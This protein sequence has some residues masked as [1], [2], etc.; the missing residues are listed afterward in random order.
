MRLLPTL[1]S[2]ISFIIIL[3]LLS[4]NDNQNI[5]PINCSITDLVAEP[6]DCNCA[7]NYGLLIDF[8]VTDATGEFF[9]VFVRNDISLGFYKLSDLPITIPKFEQSGLAEDY[10]KVCINNLPNCC[11]EYEWTPPD[12]SEECGIS[13]FTVD[14]GDCTSEETYS[15]TVNFV[16]Q[17]PGHDNFE[18]FDRNG[19]IGNYPL[20][21]LSLTIADFAPSEKEYDFLKV[22]ISDNPDCCQEIEFMAPD[23]LEVPCE[24]FDLVVE[25][26]ECTSEETY[27]LYVNFEYQNAGNDFFDL[28]VRNDV[29]IDFYRL[30]Q[31]PLTIEDFP[32][33]GNDDAYIKVCINDEPDCC[34]ILEFMP[35]EC[36]EDCEIFDVVIETGDCTSDTTYVL[37]LNFEVNNPGNDFFEVFVRNGE[38]ID[39]Y[40]LSNDRP[41]RIEDFPISGNDYDY[42]KI[43]INDEPDC[44]YEWEY[45]PPEC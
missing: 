35:P 1:A 32:F 40:E 12:C 19:R 21:S 26:G 45:M 8:K 36:E 37:E 20:S 14:V 2:L 41:L 9:E 16:T 23:C 11:A 10:I 7:D 38:L 43:C 28:Y 30:D 31:L 5:A 44:C 42:I 27:N 17:N 39:Y 33:S 18:L 13:D 29:L 34:Q 6:L 4:C 3:A 24:I 22:C 25:V 15:I